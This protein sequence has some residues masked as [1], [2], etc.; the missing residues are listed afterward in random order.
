MVI[1]KQFMLVLTKNF[2]SL[3]SRHFM[4]QRQSATYPQITCF[5]QL[6]DQ[7]LNSAFTTHANCQFDN[8]KRKSK[9]F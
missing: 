4:L 6:I 3:D 5:S 1:S 9:V 8:T 2:L 7:K